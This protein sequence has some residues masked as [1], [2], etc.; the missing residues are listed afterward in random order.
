V[1]GARRV[2]VAGAGHIVNPERPT[3]FDRAVPGF[4]ADPSPAR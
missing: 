3:E 4:L 2:V 1:K